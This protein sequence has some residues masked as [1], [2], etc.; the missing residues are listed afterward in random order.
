MEAQ[1]L[2]ILIFDVDSV[3]VDV[4]RSYHCTIVQTVRYFTRCRVRR[5]QIHRWK[6]RSGYNDDWKL[7]ADWIRALGVRVPYRQVVRKF[8]QLYLGRNFT[9]NIA[10]ERWLLARRQLERLA[11]RYEL[12]LFSG[13]P[14]REL[15]HTLK[16]FSVRRYFRRI[17]AM[18]D[19]KR[20][21][22]AP[23][24]LQR[25]LRG[26]EPCSALYVGDNVDDALAAHRAGVPFVGVLP[27]GSIARRVRARRLRR[28]GARILLSD[29]NELEKFL[30]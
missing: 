15:L 13:R 19:V 6:N 26:R 2:K 14:R 23:E 29:V 25:I 20:R 17:V 1:Q 5:S 21:K 10:Q 18:E 30:P 27:R 22:P 4:T 28:H 24:G 7:T 3:L 11:R 8:Q 12:A 9:G 16:K